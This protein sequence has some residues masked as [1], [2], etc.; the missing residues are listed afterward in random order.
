MR[1]AILR[2]ATRLGSRRRTPAPTPFLIRFDRERSRLLDL[3]AEARREGRPEAAVLCQCAGL[4]DDQA[5][6][7]RR[8]KKG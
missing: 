2:T 4:L 6:L 5:E 7:R 3:A 1:S 8:A